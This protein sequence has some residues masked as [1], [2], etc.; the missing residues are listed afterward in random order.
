[1][2]VKARGVL[3][4]GANPNLQ[5][6]QRFTLKISLACK[7]GAR[8]CRCSLAKVCLPGIRCLCPRLQRPGG[9][10]GPFFP[11]LSAL[12]LSSG[13][14]AGEIIQKRI[15]ERQLHRGEPREAGLAL[16]ALPAAGEPH[17]PGGS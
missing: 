17:F 1:M 8:E 3:W 10:Q 6:N 12:L 9:L 14:G 13:A 5:E 7:A 4:E 16:W 15:N 2:P 11:W